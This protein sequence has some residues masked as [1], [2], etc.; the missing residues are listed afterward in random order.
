VGVESACRNCGAERGG[1]YCAACGQR[2]IDPDPTLREF[3][4]ELAEE[5]LHW[6]GKLATTFRLLVTR[7]GVLTNEYLAGRRVRYI[8]PLRLYL[9]C[10]VLF[11]FLGSVVPK[12]KPAITTGTAVSTRV[13]PVEIGE[14]DSTQTIAA[15]DTLAAHGRWVGRVWG[16]HF[17]NAMRH[18][19]ELSQGL[20]AAVPKTMFVLVPLFAAL[21]GLVLRSRHRRY[22]QHLAFSLHVHAFLFLALSLMLVRRLTTVLSLQLLAGLVCLAAAALYFVQALREV[23]GGSRRGAAARALL[24][25]VIY[26]LAFVVAMIGTF[27]LLVLLQF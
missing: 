15:L 23:Y 20:G 17:A 24:I 5:L 2:A 22:P 7:P 26:L 16:R 12:P 11:F 25:G 18:R 1:E 19:G 9:T 8:S 4:H 21:V 6:D 27:G 14:S 13:G 10:S 3:L